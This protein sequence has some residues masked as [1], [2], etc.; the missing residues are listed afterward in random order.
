MLRR[1]ARQCRAEAIFALQRRVRADGL[2]EP[3]PP[4]R[5]LYV[6]GSDVLLIRGLIVGSAAVQLTA[7][8]LVFSN[9]SYLAEQTRKLAPR[10]KV[11]PL[12][13]GVDVEKFCPARR[14]R[15]RCGWCVPADSI[16]STTTST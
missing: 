5:Q 11:V 4:L 14:P 1:I 7:A 16:R 3:L 8:K 13:F 15:R 10:A 6:V 9:G 12:L 2:P